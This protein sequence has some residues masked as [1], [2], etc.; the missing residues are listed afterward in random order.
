MTELIKDNLLKEDLTNAEKEE[1][2]VKDIKNILVN[3]INTKV[4]SSE[5]EDIIELTEVVPDSDELRYNRHYNTPNNSSN[6]SNDNYNNQYYRS[7]N[8][9]ADKEKLALNNSH[10]TILSKLNNTLQELDKKEEN[11]KDN[12]KDSKAYITDIKSSINTLKE[13]R[14]L[15]EKNENSS[16]EGLVRG[17]IA[18]YIEKWLEN[19]LADIVNKEVEKAI[20]I[21][22]KDP[23]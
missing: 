4:N 20:K 19:N 10:N 17:I 11:H 14:K 1:Q 7:S 6:G 22:I 23:L 3:P 12:S 13:V 21:L 2:V 15:N 8:I 18:P 9:A 16:I 5:D